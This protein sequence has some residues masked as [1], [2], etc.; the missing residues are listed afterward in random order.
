M[1]TRLSGAWHSA[2]FV[3]DQ[4]RVSHRLRAPLRGADD[5]GLSDVI[6]Y[7]HPPAM[8]TRLRL[9]RP[10]AADTPRIC[11]SVGKFFG[12][13]RRDLRSRHQRSDL[14]AARTSAEKSFGSSQAA[15]C[16]PLSTSL[17]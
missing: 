14:N 1:S 10:E 5:G 12:D 16:P 17:K 6:F 3:G 8:A 9:F 11:R 15:K 7:A 2:H 4:G 13:Q